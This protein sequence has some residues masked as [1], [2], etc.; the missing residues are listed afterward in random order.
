MY[1]NRPTIV[2]QKKPFLYI[3]II[4]I[5]HSIASESQNGLPFFKSPAKEVV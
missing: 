3:T 1:N 4:I 5:K 2:L